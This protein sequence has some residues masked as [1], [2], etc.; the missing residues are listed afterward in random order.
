MSVALTAE[1]IKRIPDMDNVS[2]QKGVELSRT[3]VEIKSGDWAL[4][5]VPWVGGRIIAME[6]LPSGMPTT[7]MDISLKL[8]SLNN[9][10][11]DSS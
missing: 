9:R 2:G 7:T 11:L 10:L 6:H 5:V 3:P 1:S 8:Y 4:K